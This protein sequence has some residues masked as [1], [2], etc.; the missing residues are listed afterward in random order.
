[1]GRRNDSP[2]MSVVASRPGGSDGVHTTDKVKERYELEKVRTTHAALRAH[3]KSLSLS[4]EQS[5]IEGDDCNEINN[6]MQYDC[7]Y[8]T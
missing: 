2:T 7:A 1:M 5:T 4:L 6:C 3:C 8:G